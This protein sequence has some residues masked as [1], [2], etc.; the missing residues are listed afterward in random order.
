MKIWYINQMDINN[1]LLHRDL[2]EI[3]YMFIPDGVTTKPNQVCRLQKNLYGLKQVGRKWH[4][5]LAH[6]LV[7]ER[8]H[9]STS[10]Y[11]IFTPMQREEFIV[12]LVH[13]I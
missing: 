7:Q 4:E 11:S 10:D 8:Y 5:K 1:A 3:V 12:L 2:Q 13:V 6:I 9:Q